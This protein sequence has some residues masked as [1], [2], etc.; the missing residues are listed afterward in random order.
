[1]QRITAD[2]LPLKDAAREYDVHYNT[3][4]GWIRR[5]MV[6]HIDIGSAKRTSFVFVHEADVR[7]RAAIVHGESPEGDGEGGAGRLAIA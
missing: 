1:M 5:G 3:I 4:R 7:R 2:Y 6:R